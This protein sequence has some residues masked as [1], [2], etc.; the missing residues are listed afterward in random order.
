MAT[1]KASMAGQDG[2]APWQ[3]MTKA[4][5]SRTATDNAAH[6]IPHLRPYHRV[7]DVGCGP[8]SI[9]IDLANIVSN[10]H[11]VGIDTNPKWISAAQ[12]SATERECSNIE[13]AIGD[14]YDLSIFP[15]ESFDIVHAH[16]V[17]L[18][19]ASPVKAVKEMRRVLKAGGILSTRDNVELYHYPFNSW[20]QKNRDYFS[21]F[22][23]QAGA[24]PRGGLFNHDWTH[25]AGFAWEKIQTSTASMEYNTLEERTR[26]AEGA[27]N[28]FRAIGLKAGLGTKEEYDEMGQAWIDWSK[29]DEGRLALL[30]GCVLAWK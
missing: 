30:D 28:S 19:L 3:N 18:H 25:Q 29:K 16:Q 1:T 9:T 26:W 4:F 2:K 21:K 8:G 5:G 10:G 27:K 11:V 17:L 20:I 23:R 13:F 6:L 7:L 22:G 15:D 12:D 14:I 24:E